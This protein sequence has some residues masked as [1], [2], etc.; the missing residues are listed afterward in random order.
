MNAI[1]INWGPC[2]WD[3]SGEGVS[4]SY[5]GYEAD[6]TPTIVADGQKWFWRVDATSDVSEYPEVYDCGHSATRADGQDAA[7]TAL[8]KAAL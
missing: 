6:V 5:A 3:D 2:E 4:A 1:G 8:R 7:E